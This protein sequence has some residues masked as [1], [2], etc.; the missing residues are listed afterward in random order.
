MLNY[1][2]IHHKF[3]ISFCFPKKKNIYVLSF[4][5]NVNEH[6]QHNKNEK[7]HYIW[8]NHKNEFE[9]KFNENEF[10]A[11]I[12]DR[13]CYGIWCWLISTMNVF[14]TFASLP[15]F[16]YKYLT[17]SVSSILTT[18][19]VHVNTPHFRHQSASI[20]IYSHQSMWL[21]REFHLLKEIQKKRNENNVKWIKINLLAITSLLMKIELHSRKLTI[22]KWSSKIQTFVFGYCCVVKC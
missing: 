19:L 1:I 7:H 8:S 16:R 11:A 18:Q 17:H 20:L 10:S 6:A 15:F 22:L 21:D 14:R 5:V 2:Q 3:S 9:R 12:A 4:N 13:Y